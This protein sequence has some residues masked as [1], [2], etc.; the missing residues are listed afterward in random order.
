MKHT[1]PVPEELA[2]LKKI[3]KLSLK[4]AHNAVESFAAGNT[5]QLSDPQ[6]DALET[7]LRLDGFIEDSK[8]IS[9]R[10]IVTEI[11]KRFIRDNTW[12]RKW[13][14]YARTIYKKYFDKTIAEYTWPVFYALFL[15][16]VYEVIEIFISEKLNEYFVSKI[17]ALFKPSNF[18][19]F[20]FLFFTVVITWLNRN[21]K[22]NTWD[23]FFIILYIRYRFF[24][25]T[26]D[27]M[28]LFQ[29]DNSNNAFPLYIDAIGLY[30]S[31]L[32]AWAGI[33]KIRAY[34]EVQEYDD[35]MF[36]PDLSLSRQ[37]GKTRQSM[38]DLDSEGLKRNRFASQIA[39]VI[40]QM[41]PFEAF[42][43][44][45]CG[46]WGS[47]KTSLIEMIIENLKKNSTKREYLYVEFSPWFFNNSEML[48]TNFFSVLEAKFRFN[49][50]LAAEL[51]AYGKEI[52]MVEKSILKTEFSKLAL[53]GHTGLKERYQNIFEGI[54]SEKKILVIT[55]DDLDRLD[56]KEIVDVLRLIRLVADF[57]NTFYIVGYDRGY[58]NSAIEHE[59]TKYK[60]EKY[61]DKVFNIEFKIP[62]ISPDVIRERL[63]T[64]VRNQLSRMKKNI[65]PVDAEELRHC[66]EYEDLHHT[67]KNER[68]IKRF[69]NNLLI[70]YLSIKQ[71]I[72]FFHF[73]LL[74]LIYYCDQDVYVAICENRKP[75]F[76]YY[77][78]MM[79]GS[80]AIQE[81][82]GAILNIKLNGDIEKLVTELFKK[83]S[84]LANR[85]L[86]NELYFNRYFSLSI[87]PG[88]F[89]NED[90]EKSF[91]EPVEKLKEKLVEFNSSNSPMLAEK[92]F[93]KAKDLELSDPDKLKKI[94]DS[95]LFLYNDIFHSRNSEALSKGVNA[96]NLR[97]YIFDL[98]LSANADIDFLS[99]RILSFDLQDYSA[100]SFLAGIDSI[101]SLSS[102]TSTTDMEK[103]YQSLRKV[104]IELLDRE[105]AANG[106]TFSGNIISQLQNLRRFIRG[107]ETHPPD[108]L[109]WFSEKVIIDHK[110][111][112]SKNLK[113]IMV[114]I[115]ENG[116]EGN[117]FD[118]ERV[119][120]QVESIFLD[121]ELP[122]Y[123]LPIFDTL[124]DFFRGY[125]TITDRP[126]SFQ[127]KTNSEYPKI[128][129]DIYADTLSLNPGDR[130]EITVD[131]LQTPYW[132]FGFRLSRT[133]EFPRLGDSRHIP[134]YPFIHLNKGF[135]LDGGEGKDATPPQ[136]SVAVYSGNELLT[137]QPIIVN[138]G[139]EPVSF[140]I[141]KDEKGTIH[142]E[143][144]KKTNNVNNVVIDQFKDYSFAQISAWADERVFVLA[145]RVRILKKIK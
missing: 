112:L 29:R 17:L 89:S 100:F 140:S 8:E 139:N 54:K 21:R 66:F 56:K 49:R 84:H 117:Y 123:K 115:K 11:G 37:A 67:V 114:F 13:F 111:F 93:Y 134:D 42:A 128:N 44:G 38:T 12:Y 85:S 3:Q 52:S 6:S 59:L 122:V 104:Q 80:S 4:S 39:E 57:P 1:K 106:D 47:G 20:S 27:F 55:I 138:Y 108:D 65:G 127:N 92:L 58:I 99:E 95:L 97:K 33:K 131:P 142:C 86:T 7:R 2:Y 22:P 109:I 130:F 72:N 145:T 14:L 137:D 31:V 136:L 26:W 70:R 10:V 101:V 141:E 63:E 62:E 53:D 90:F 19:D 41:V 18:F 15:F 69:T 121:L 71:E 81:N 35:G 79:A 103:W 23:F 34:Y 16:L 120:E 74:E 24:H 113:N 60:P 51:K 125:E 5:L 129:D 73:F 64:S 116:Y 91:E 94:T 132:R 102:S 68:D 78:G 43:I 76:E 105:I 83:N 46:P 50:F 110:D 9:G 87:L 133:R 25:S 77:R 119:K 36:Y 61:I 126:Y 40:Q 28:A 118:L 96:N 48:I 107:L 75:L 32:F 45:I 143:V 144:D 30:Y 88:D 82:F 124:K 98:I 135:I